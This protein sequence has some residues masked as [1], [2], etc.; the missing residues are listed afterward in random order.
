MPS[1][2]ARLVTRFTVALGWLALGL[3]ATNSLAVDPLPPCVSYKVQVNWC[4]PA[5]ALSV[6]SDW[7]GNAN[8]AACVASGKDVV[9]KKKTECADLPNW[10]IGYTKSVCIDA[11]QDGQPVTELCSEQYACVSVNKGTVQQPQWKCERGALLIP[12]DRRNAKTDSDDCILPA[13]IIDWD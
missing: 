6:C 12:P 9:Q 11:T 7:D 2:R 3:V 1:T 13:P 5:V 8:A 4:V 10:A